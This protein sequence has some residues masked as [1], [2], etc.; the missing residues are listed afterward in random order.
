MTY[1]SLDPEG[2]QKVI[3]GLSSYVSKARDH[4]ES[5]KNTNHRNSSPADLASSLEIIAGSAAALEDKV[6]ELQ[7]RLDSAKAAN[8]SGITPM[9]ADGTISYV[10]PDGLKDTAENARAN[11]NVEI[12]NQARADAETLKKYDSGGYPHG[13]EKEVEAFIERMKAKQ[14]DP[15]YANV[16]LSNV[17]PKTLRGIAARFSGDPDA[18]GAPVGL[19][20]EQATKISNTLPHILATASNTWSTEKAKN[21][22]LQLTEDMDITGQVGLDKLFSASRDV[23]IDEDGQNESVGLDYNDSMLV[24]VAREIE[25]MGEKGRLSK[26]YDESGHRYSAIVHA[27]TGNVDAST[28]WLTV[29]HKD[30]N[31]MVDNKA[32]AERIKNL[33]KEGAVA[34]SDESQWTDDW[35]LISAQNAAS[36]SVNDPLKGAGKAAIVSGIL[37]TAGS[38]KTI[39]LSDNAR[40][41]ASISLSAYPLAIQRCAP[42]DDPQVKT[43]DT[44]NNGWS[45]DMPIQPLFDNRALT[46]ITGQIGKNN[47]AITRLA[48][49]QEIFNKNQDALEITDDGYNNICTNYRTQSSVRG[50]IAGAIARQAEIDG[51]DADKRVATWTNAGALA[52]SA[53][54]L[55]GV[56][57]TAGQFVKFGAEFAM[58]WGRSMAVDGAKEGITNGAANEESDVKMKNEK[59]RAAGENI[60]VQ[61]AGLSLLRRGVFSQ[62]TLKKVYDEA[63]GGAVDKVLT[64]EGKLQEGI[65][66]QELQ[67][68]IDL[69]NGINENSN[70]KQPDSISAEQA[71]QREQVRQVIERAPKEGA[72]ENFNTNIGNAY[73]KAYDTARELEK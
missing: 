57:Q 43:M 65:D 58:N 71:A 50:F 26:R 60:N 48:G 3:D 4:R 28:E 39:Q 29:Y 56:S 54:P 51:A 15:V 31:E 20:P 5:V 11:N 14:S 46:N 41:A 12:A 59:I 35:M 32:T 33:M 70:E 66:L 22:G 72:L 16:I 64:P 27:M 53:V 13:D 62:E 19:T 55:P 34:S 2:L 67:E 6:K 38:G 47:L 7:A 45:K 21:Y 25:A 37:N 18:A 68:G 24:T 73:S 63:Q 42:S 8:E 61:N 69:Q 44:A 9:G 30:N 10:I 17:D 36:S 23:D 1:V 52:A 40:N 49:S